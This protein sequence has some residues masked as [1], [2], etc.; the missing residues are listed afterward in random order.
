M[1]P[2]TSGVGSEHRVPGPYVA[3]FDSFDHI[4]SIVKC[5]AAG[6]F[7]YPQLHAEE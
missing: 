3:M 2:G 6:Y 4:V 1:K 7:K 5:S